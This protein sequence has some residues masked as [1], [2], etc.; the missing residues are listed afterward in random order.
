MR[1]WKLCAIAASVMMSCS[2]SAG[3]H[4]VE[5]ERRDLPEETQRGAH[6]IAGDAAEDRVEL[7]HHCVYLRTERVLVE[8]PDR[9]T[10]L[11]G[12]VP[13]GHESPRELSTLESVASG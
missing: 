10:K 13:L 1:A 4:L 9:T 6:A 11:G 2:A 8:R 12:R 7:A 3:R 5:L